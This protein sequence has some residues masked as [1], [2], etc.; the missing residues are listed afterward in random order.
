MCESVE[1]FIDYFI[2]LSDMI[3]IDEKIG[4]IV[5][6]KLNN[7]AYEVELTSDGEDEYINIIVNI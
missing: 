2:S 5:N 7:G 4:A 6:E 3:E 1:E